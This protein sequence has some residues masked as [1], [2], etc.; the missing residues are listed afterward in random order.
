M[1]ARTPPKPVTLPPGRAKPWTKPLPI[2]SETCANTVSIA[3]VNRCNSANAGLAE[4]TST[5]G[6]KPTN[7]TASCWVRLRGK[8]C[9]HLSSGAPGNASLAFRID[10]RVAARK[11]ADASQSLRLLRAR[12]ERPRCR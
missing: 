11:H 2:G 10:L 5:S 12:C 8:R 4:T 7:S 9:A 6:A 3:L 1:T